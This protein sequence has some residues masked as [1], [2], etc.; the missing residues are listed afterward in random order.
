MSV[1]IVALVTIN[2]DEPQALAKY[3]AVTMPL[4]E[5]AGAKIVQRFEVQEMVV[6]HR[7]AKTIMVVEYPDRSAIDWVFKS[8]EYQ[9]VKEIR[10]VAFLDYQVS[11]VSV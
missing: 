9:S 6:G 5:K 7:P 10:D 2:E 1:T 4:L 11:I 3:L 8:A